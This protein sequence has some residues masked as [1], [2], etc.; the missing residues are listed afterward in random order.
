MCRDVEEN[1]KTIS[2]ELLKLLYFYKNTTCSRTSDLS[3][4]G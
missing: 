4:L 2:D 1:A 3:I